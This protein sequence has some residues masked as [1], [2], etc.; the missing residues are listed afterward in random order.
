V[1]GFSLCKPNFGGNVGAL[2]RK[3]GAAE[4]K[5]DPKTDVRGYANTP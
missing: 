4:R 2:A 1:G 5:I 3:F